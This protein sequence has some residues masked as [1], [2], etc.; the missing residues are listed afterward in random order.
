ML[1]KTSE[2]VLTFNFF[3]TFASALVMRAKGVD[4]N[5]YFLLQHAA[6]KNCGWFKV[7]QSTFPSISG[8]ALYSEVFPMRDTVQPEGQRCTYRTGFSAKGGQ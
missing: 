7:C 3:S 6:F 4:K 1:G 5:L 8:K 2:S